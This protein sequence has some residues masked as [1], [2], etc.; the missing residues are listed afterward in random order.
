MQIGDG[1]DLEI[2][3]SVHVVSYCLIRLRSSD[4]RQPAGSGPAGL[5]I[6]HLHLVCT[7]FACIPRELL[8]ALFNI[9]PHCAVGEATSASDNVFFFPRCRSKLQPLAKMYM[10]AMCLGAL[11]IRKVEWRFL[12]VTSTVGFA[13]NTGSCQPL[14]RQVAYVNI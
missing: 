3:Y 9:R 8:L 1:F 11:N 2:N 5:L 6:T 14:V 13:C 12:H 7:H 10:I 4:C